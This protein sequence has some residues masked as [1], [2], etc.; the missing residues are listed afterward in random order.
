MFSISLP[1]Q[2]VWHSIYG[3]SALTS[4]HIQIC[5]SSRLLVGLSLVLSAADAALS[6][7][8][9]PP[10]P[11]WSLNV[12]PEKKMMEKF[13]LVR[14]PTSPPPTLCVPVGS[15]EGWAKVNLSNVVH[16]SYS[17]SGDV[18]W[19]QPSLIFLDSASEPFLF[20]LPVGV[21]AACSSLSGAHTW[22]RMAMFKRSW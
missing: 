15:V 4:R 14:S 17:N 11:V 22:N 3:H 2:Y 21:W 16:S 6:L 13:T 9:S 20:L 12:Q 1:V 10:S 5:S 7:F 19:Y 18:S 8:L